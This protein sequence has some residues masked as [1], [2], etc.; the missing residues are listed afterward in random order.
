[1]WATAAYQLPVVSS[2]GFSNNIL[3]KGGGGEKGMF[4]SQSMSSSKNGIIT[5]L[6]KAIYE[7]NYTSFLHQNCLNYKFSPSQ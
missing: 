5:P 3:E 2:T 6:G 7:P 1:M 4:S